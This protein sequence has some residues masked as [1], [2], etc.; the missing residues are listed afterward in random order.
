ML[1][2]SKVSLVHTWRQ[3]PQVLPLS[4]PATQ[5]IDKF[6]IIW[7]SGVDRRRSPEHMWRYRTS[8]WDTTSFLI[9]FPH[10]RVAAVS[11]SHTVVQSPYRIAVRPT[12][13]LSPYC[14]SPSRCRSQNLVEIRPEVEVR[15][16]SICRGLRR[17]SFQRLDPY[18]VRVYDPVV[19]YIAMR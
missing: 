13:K 16:H 18:Y 2:N 17:H 12:S 15:L 4:A 10:L 5:W 3:R 11:T 1:G 14:D 6:A 19:C 7:C 8:M 9:G